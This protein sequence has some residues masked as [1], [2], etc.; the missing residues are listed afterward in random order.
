MFYVTM[1]WKFLNNEF[2]LKSS[3]AMESSIQVTSGPLEAGMSSF[4]IIPSGV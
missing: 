2:K 1:D 3:K 4:V